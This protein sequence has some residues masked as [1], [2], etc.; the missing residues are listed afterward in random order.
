MYYFRVKLNDPMNS[1]ALQANE[2]FEDN[3][4]NTDMT[5]EAEENFC[6]LLR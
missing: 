2:M 1:L 4:L 6:K 5:F 3:K